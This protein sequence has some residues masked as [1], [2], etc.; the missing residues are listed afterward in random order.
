MPQRAADHH[1]RTG[2]ILPLPSG[3]SSSRCATYDRVHVLA[4]QVRNITGAIVAAGRGLLSAD[5]VFRL[6]LNQ[7]RR[8]APPPAPPQGLYLAKVTY[9]ADYLRVD[10]FP[11][12]AHN[13]NGHDDSDGDDATNI[14]D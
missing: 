1:H 13:A 10:S 12:C 5:D 9:P 2:P 8:D 3:L 7:Q 4:T 6:L 14:E 11:L